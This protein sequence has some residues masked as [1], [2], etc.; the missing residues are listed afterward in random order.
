MKTGSPAAVMSLM[1][2]S[3]AWVTARRLFDELR[4]VRVEIG[5]VGA[6]DPLKVGPKVLSRVFLAFLHRA[7]ERIP[8]GPPSMMMLT[9][10]S[11]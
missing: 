7:E 8:E 6:G 5:G 1:I 11:A 2:G 9:L 4:V 3:R 10:S